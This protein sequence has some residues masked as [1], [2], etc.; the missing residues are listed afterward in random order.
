MNASRWQVEIEEEGEYK[1]KT[2]GFLPDPT[3]KVTANSTFEVYLI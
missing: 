2:P 1:I 3:I